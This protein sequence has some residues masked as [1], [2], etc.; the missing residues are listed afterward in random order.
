MLDFSWNT[1]D[2]INL[3]LGIKNNMSW[4]YGPWLSLNTNHATEKYIYNKLEI[5]LV[6]YIEL[7]KS[8]RLWGQQCPFTTLSKRKENS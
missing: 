1:V 5:K 7:G 6:G 4:I 2:C 8:S 3:G